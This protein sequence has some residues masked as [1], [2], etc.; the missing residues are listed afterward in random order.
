M[1]TRTFFRAL[2]LAVLATQASARSI[3]GRPGSFIVDN[4]KR[5]LLQD[6]VTFDNSS[7]F[8]RG[9]RVALYSGEFH[10][11]RLPVPSL[12]LDVFQKIKALGYNGVSFYTDW[13]LLEGKPGN[14]SAEGIFDFQPF[15]DAA[16]AA[17]IY[18]LA[19]P[20]PYINA[21]ASGGGFPGWLGRVPGIPR[22]YDE[23]YLNATNNYVKN[24]G[25]IIAK[26]QITNG[27]PVILLQPENEY[28]VANKGEKFP[29]PDYFNYVKQQFRDAGIIVPFISNDASPGGRDAPGTAAPVDI[30]GHDSYPLGFDC[31]NPEVW[32]DNAL[33]TYFHTLH[34]EQSPTTPYSLVEF[35]GG[36]F[37][38]WGGPGFAKCLSLVNDQFERVFYKNNFA[39]GATI[40]NIY[41]TAG[42]TN[43]GNLGHPGGYSSYDYGSPI[44]E[45]RSVAREKYSEAKLLANFI[46]AST[47][48]LTAVPQNNTNA[49]G[50]FTGDTSIAVSQ[51]I[52]NPTNF[53]Y[54]RHAAYNSLDTTNY[55]ITLPTSQ[56][57][58]TIPQLGGKLSLLGRDSTIH[59]TDYDVGGTSLLYSTADIFTWKKYSSKT[60]LVVYGAPGTTQELAI[61]TNGA[62]T[63]LE[64]HGAQIVGSNGNVIINYVAGPS[65]QVVKVGS[66]FYIYLLDRNSAYNFWTVDLPTG[67]SSGDP[68]VGIKNA[69]IVNGPYLVRTAAVD[70][71][72]LSLTGDIN[73]T[74]TVEVIG[75][76]PDGLTC[77]NFNGKSVDF[78]LSAEGVA[79]ATII[80]ETPNFAIPDLSKATWKTIDS[81][82]EIQA[83]YDDSLWTNASLTYSNN[84][85]R[86][87]TTPTSL[88]SV[89]YGY[90]TGNLV[91]RG[92]FVATGQET[93]LRI[94][95]QGGSAYGASFW[96][97]STFL[98]SFYGYDAASN[99]N[100]SIPL[101]GL[102]AGQEYIITVLVDNQG[103]DENY[104]I[105]SSGA[106][107]PRGVIDYDLVGRPQSAIT[108][109]LTGNLGGEDFRDPSRGPL[110]EGGLFIERQGYHLPGAPT[111]S[112]T[113]SSGPTEGISHAG[114]QFYSTTF[115]LNVPE[116]YDIPLSLSF[117]NATTLDASGLSVAFRCQVYVN[118][119]QFGKYVNNVG[120]QTQFPVPQGIWNYNGSNYLGVTLWALEAGGAKV[121]NFTIVAGPVVQSGLG[122]VEN[123][124]MVGWTQ[125]EGA[126]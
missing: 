107:N 115:D 62:A 97:G 45:D 2:S 112:W 98:T 47:A 38:P 71:T 121:D 16:S 91:Y 7:L 119:Y 35:Q 63:C 57:S 94:S 58:I 31:A 53:Y 41:M 33:P 51:S 6:I 50:S 123:S 21:E 126:Y 3:A 82:P 118:G 52:G 86:N 19:R 120:P 113:S 36:S 73:A 100:L 114:V 78:K 27:G 80:L 75:G 90:S 11:F 17:G 106:K 42:L 12:W 79:T 25:E 72:T 48:Y 60:V 84:T 124:P 74:T 66:N 104:S 108:W 76:A 105:G 70:G 34:E 67:L 64:D 24:M 1:L 8:I 92:R 32:P 101:T 14:F 46:R 43:W 29:D 15:F 89:D 85:A 37:D 61:K 20:G 116:G 13:A 4:S 93:E 28:S 68:N 22:T 18:L 69:A 77:L 30:Y 81:L 83:N 103:L 49:N 109:K 117:T 122:K 23:S 110:N 40:F 96:L 56:G 87:L 125:R 111:S 88:Y 9:E 10:P 102:T 39:F 44:A 99:S 26:G 54:V 5:E 95:T 55:T 65:R 59:V